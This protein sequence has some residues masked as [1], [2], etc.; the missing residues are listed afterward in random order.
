MTRLSVP[1]PPPADARPQPRRSW[2]A[3]VTVGVLLGTTLV[4][5]VAAVLGYRD[6]HPWWQWLGVYVA[7]LCL[8][9]VVIVASATVSDQPD[10]IYVCRCGR[11]RS[12][13]HVHW[14]DGI[15]HCEDCQPREA[16]CA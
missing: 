12:W 5:A 3:A 10:R 4:A 15:A 6:G 1:L 9:V 13:R 2:A 11:V 7:L 14:H 8:C 16:S